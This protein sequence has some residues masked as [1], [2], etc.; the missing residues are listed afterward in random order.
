MARLLSTRVWAGRIAAA[1]TI[2]SNNL[3]GRTRLSL[4]VSN[5]RAIVA[6]KVAGRESPPACD[7]STSPVL[8]IAPRRHDHRNRVG[9]PCVDASIRRLRLRMHARQLSVC[10]LRLSSC[11]IGGGFFIS[12]AAAGPATADGQTAESADANGPGWRSGGGEQASSSRS[13][14]ADSASRSQSASRQRDASR[15]SWPA[16]VRTSMI[17]P[18]RDI[19]K[20]CSQDCTEGI[21]RRTHLPGSRFR[22][23]AAITRGTRTPDSRRSG[24]LV[25]PAAITQH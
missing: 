17:L 21:T 10:A 8:A 11:L 13:R 4:P 23:K 2:I 18:G 7:R 14:R 20:E 9:E 3:R 16:V 24:A 1:K 15:V 12:G 5:K 19:A 25:E 22:Q 6:P